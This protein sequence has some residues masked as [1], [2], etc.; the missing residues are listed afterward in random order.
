MACDAGCGDACAGVKCGVSGADLWGEID[1][2]GY[3]SFFC[4][5][6]CGEINAACFSGICVGIECGFSGVGSCETD[7]VCY[8]MD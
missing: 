5:D 7:I 3:S 1:V 4:K 6:L 8:S 2:D